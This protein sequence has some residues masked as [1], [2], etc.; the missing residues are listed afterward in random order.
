VSPLLLLLAAGPAPRAEVDRL[1][2]AVEA[3]RSDEGSFAERLERL[4]RPFLGAPYLLSPLGEEARPDLDPRIRGDAFDCTT[5]VETAL[6]LARDPSKPRA[7]LDRVRYDGPPRFENRRHLIESQWLPGLEAEGLIED[8]TATLPGARTLRYTLDD[9]RWRRRRIARKLVLP[10]DKIPFGTRSLSY[11]PLAAVQGALH[12]IPAGTIVNAVRVDWAGSPVLITHQGIVFVRGEERYVR[13][14]SPVSKRVIDEPL[15]K[16]LRRYEK[17]RK[18]P[19]L[20]LN[21]A[22]ILPG[23]PSAP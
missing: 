23:P 1:P 17:P 8:L 9:A 11:L 7:S 3:A 18:W 2:R 4:T 19:Y 5:F 20:G 10:E 13:H 16:V 6:A 15:A 14:A 21:F 22:R 12:E